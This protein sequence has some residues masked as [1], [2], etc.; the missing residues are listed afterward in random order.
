MAVEDYDIETVTTFTKDQAKVTAPRYLS[1]PQGSCH[2]LCKF[3]IQNATTE[4]KPWKRAKKR[5][6]VSTGGIKNK[7]QEE[8][9]T[10]LAWT[11]KSGINSKPSTTSKF[12]SSNTL[13]DIK[14]VINEETVNSKKNSPPSAETNVS[15]KEH[16]NNDLRKSVSHS[17][18]SPK[19][20]F[21]S[22]NS[23]VDTKEVIYEAAVNS[24]KN[25]TTE[26]TNVS[27]KGHK[28]KKQ[29]NSDKRFS[30]K[31]QTNTDL[32]ISTKEHNRRNLWQAQQE[33]SK[34]LALIGDKEYPSHT[35]G[36][37][38]KDKVV[39]CS[40]SIKHS[41][42]NSKQKTKLSLIE[43][44]TTKT[45][46]KASKCTTK[47]ASSLNA[48]TTKN[49]KS[50]SS[51][52]GN[53]KV[54]AK[55]ELA[56]NDILHEIVHTLDEE[57]TLPSDHSMLPSAATKGLNHAGHGTC[58]S[59]S[60]SI[61]SAGG[62]G[63][64]SH[65][66]TLSSSSLSLISFGNKGKISH[67]RTPSGSFLPLIN[68][69]SK[70]KKSH[71]RTPSGSS[72]PLISSGGKGKKSHSRSI[73]LSDFSLNTSNGKPGKKS[74]SR[75]TSLSDFSFNGKPLIS[76]GGKGKKSHS[77]STS[78]SDFSDFSLNTSNGK[79]HDDATLKKTGNSE[80]VKMGYQVKP[81]VSTVVG[82][83]NKVAPR[84]LTFRRG[85]VIEIQPENNNIPRRLKFRPV[86]T[87]NYDNPR[88]INAPTNVITEIYSP[89]FQI[90]EAI[91]MRSIARETGTEVDGSKPESEEEVLIRPPS[92][93]KKANRRLY[94]NVIEETA[95]MLAEVRKSKVKALV[96]AFETVISIDSRRQSRSALPEVSTP[97]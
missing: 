26:E 94:N 41:E 38:I 22:S 95:T 70:G 17:K 9:I 35:K 25:S 66:R 77:R 92:V 42:I 32:R 36:E 54:E 88:D 27:T 30:T 58:P 78:L 53:E 73:S 55:P 37:T 24:E 31:E 89:K 90:A 62:E 84:K 97:C 82:E 34:I 11:K 43:G 61:L 83:T 49:L 79:Q 45:T 74:H 10:S 29:N 48:K 7:V 18:P 50:V 3:G 5:V 2:D 39:S 15:T 13:A 51:R 20:K 56:S 71:S 57:H 28:K 16:N 52:K 87:L 86:R 80:N 46:K 8:N 76:S 72:L 4:A 93:E 21:G 6:T 65:T 91:K 1:A 69:G 12:G 59:E 14:E 67:S 60:M 81:R 19:S 33:S 40:S 44:K 96:G 64:R 47:K 85:K 23:L 75:S 63:K 68:F